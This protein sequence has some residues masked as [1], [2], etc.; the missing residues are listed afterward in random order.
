MLYFDVHFMLLKT[1]S[2]IN[3]FFVN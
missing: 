3:K 1:M 2:G